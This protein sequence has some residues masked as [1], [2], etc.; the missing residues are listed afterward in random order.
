M[1]FRST[2]MSVESMPP[3]LV[4]VYA[5]DYD[6]EWVNYQLGHAVE[7]KFISPDLRFTRNGGRSIVL[8]NGLSRQRYDLKQLN[9]SNRY[10]RLEH[11]NVLYGC[12]KAHQEE[13]DLDF[14]AITH[15]FMG[16]DVAK[17]KHGICYT[18]PECQRQ[19][20]SMNLIPLYPRMDAGATAAMLAAFHGADRIFLFGFD[21]QNDPKHN[22]NIYA[23]T[24]HYGSSTDKINDRDWHLNLYKVIAGYKNTQFYRV[25]VSPPGARILTVLPNY[26]VIPFS[27][28][29]S[30]ADL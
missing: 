24:D 20:K 8:G 4:P 13:G 9:H 7:R 22:N 2:N 23:D 16:R 1:T 14:I 5:K 25:D 28:F 21:G 15:R 30:L 11:Y 6:G 12:N 3:A 17:D 26:K 29:V 18:T 27:M 19:H 10:K